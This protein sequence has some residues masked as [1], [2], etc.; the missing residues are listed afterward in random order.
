M[1]S[2]IPFE[3]REGEM[4]WTYF[5]DWTPHEE[6]WDGDAY[7]CI[8]KGC[9]CVFRTKEEALEYLPLKYKMLTG[10]DWSVKDA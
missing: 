8:H 10:R 1:D 3:P 6:I 2:K 7:D 5:G 4:Y 9:G